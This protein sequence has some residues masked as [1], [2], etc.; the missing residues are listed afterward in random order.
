MYHK[1]STA[2]YPQN[3]ICIQVVASPA[4]IS[5]QSRLLVLVKLQVEVTSFMQPY[6]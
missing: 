2:A 6:T 4:C 1:K 5:V 3:K